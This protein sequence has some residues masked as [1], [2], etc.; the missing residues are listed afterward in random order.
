MNAIRNLPTE[1]RVVEQQRYADSKK[2]NHVRYQILDSL[3]DDGEIPIDV[4]ESLKE[5][6][7]AKFDTNIFLR[8][9]NYEIIGQLYFDFFR[10]RIDG[11]LD[12]LANFIATELDVSDHDIHTVHFTEPRNFL[13]DFAWLAIYPGE[14]GD[15]R[16]EY[17][18]YLGVHWNRVTY[19]LHVG[20]NLRDE[21]DWK[22]NRNLEKIQTDESLS[23]DTVLGKL[24][25][26][27]ANYLA[28]NDISR[29]V[30]PPAKPSQA[31]EI[32]R[33]L[34]ATNQAIFY[35]PPGTGKTYTAHRFAQWWVH[36][37]TS[38][39]SVD[40]QI[41]IVTF[42]PSFSYEDFIEGLTAEANDGAVEYRIE[43]G[44]FKRI[45]QRAQTAYEYANQQ[46]DTDEAPPYV[47]IIDEINRGNLAQIFGEVITLLEADKRGNFEIELAHSG[48]TFTVPP[49]LYVIGTMNTADQSI[50]LVDT[51]L[52]RRFRF[53]DFPPDLDIVFEQYDIEPLDAQAAVTAHSSGIS[54]QERL[55]GA[56]V[57]AAHELNE[58][59]LDAPQLGKGKQLGHTYFLIHDSSDDIVDAWRYDILPQLEEYYFGQFDRLRDELLNEIDTRLIDW[60]TERIQSFDDQAL[61]SAL[62]DLAGVEDPAPLADAMQAIPDGN[63]TEALQ[64]QPDDAW[65]AGDR[66]PETFRERLQSIL[67]DDSAEK[68]VRILDIGDD[69]GWLDTG[70]GDRASIMLKSDSVDSG[71]GII[72]LSQDGRIDFRWNWLLDRD[73]NPL[74]REFI[75][76]ASRVFTNISGYEHRWNPEKG[77]EGGFVDPRLYVSDLSEEDITALSEGLQSFTERAATFQHD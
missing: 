53:I 50:A 30:E 77:E 41:Q 3:S 47:L 65:A 67:D 71:V 26:V 51:A 23:I 5:K 21:E 55:L 43:E 68:M 27:K 64:G 75:E 22:G 48:E 8:W 56:S 4:L 2:I 7:A 73:T 17:Q 35:G 12:R 70:R 25:D 1:Y 49:N 29:P 54:R 69:I 72:Q 24:H 13:S 9:G 18:L 76:G 31:D 6:E 32:A 34:L 61:Y 40:E 19:G 36:N 66:T 46:E 52:R 20:G 38:S 45:C 62:C 33:Q 57:L 14:I 58:R 74:D 60:E 28:L 15:Q 16:D 10:P 59:I 63:G 11:Y 39:E 37:Q 44:V 42:H